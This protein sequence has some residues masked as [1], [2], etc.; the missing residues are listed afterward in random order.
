MHVTGM[1]FALMAMLVTTQ[2][3]GQLCSLA[4]PNLGFPDAKAMTGSIVGNF[5]G[6]AGDC[7]DLCTNNTSCAGFSFNANK[8]D[9]FLHPI[10]SPLGLPQN[11]NGVTSGVLRPAASPQRINPAPPGAKNVLFII[12]DDLRPEL[13][14][15][16]PHE[17]LTVT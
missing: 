4:S 5:Y 13:M 10:D 2:A 9:C 6:S 1:L 14:E 12:S 11:K 7:C 3:T 16:V 15:A 8:R 17:N